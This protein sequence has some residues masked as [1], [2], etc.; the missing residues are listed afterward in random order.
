MVDCR[1]RHS[2]YLAVALE[3]T[4]IRDIKHTGG[5]MRDE[6]TPWQQALIE[7]EPSD[8][9]PDADARLAEFFEGQYNKELHEPEGSTRN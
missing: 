4:F 7:A 9:T 2:Y 8:Y 3:F 5:L 1:H 6:M